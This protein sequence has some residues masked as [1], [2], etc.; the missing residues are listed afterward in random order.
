MVFVGSFATAFPQSVDKLEQQANMAYVLKNYPDALKAYSEIHA[1]GFESADLYYNLGNTYYKMDS[2]PSAILYYEKALKLD[3]SNANAR[4]NLELANS[5]VVDKIEPIPLL[6]YSQWILTIRNSMS[7]DSFA[8]WAI[9][10]FTV[11]FGLFAS[12]LIFKRTVIRKSAF[13]A[14]I[15]I[16]LFAVSALLFAQKNYAALKNPAEAILMTA[17]VDARSSPD[18]AS[19]ILFVLHKGTKVKILDQVGS[20]VEIRIANG[21]EGW[22]E[23]AAMQKI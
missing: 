7:A 2:I 21:S 23:S 8:V 16:F 22:V 13:W 15:I 6:F 14:S 9:V 17:V 11:A 18:P 20:W 10:L 19:S 4:F 5:K 3:P 1:K 12:F